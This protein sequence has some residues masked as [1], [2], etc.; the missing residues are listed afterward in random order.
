MFVTEVAC[1]SVYKS[2]CP[3]KNEPSPLQGITSQM[4]KTKR[5]IE[6]S[7]RERHRETERQRGRETER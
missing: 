3:T 5:E 6:G 2:R 4:R 1:L 7:E